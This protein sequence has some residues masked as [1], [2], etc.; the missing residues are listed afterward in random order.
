M[1]RIIFPPTVLCWRMFCLVVSMVFCALLFY[2]NVALPCIFKKT[3]IRKVCQ[4]KKKK[5]KERKKAYRKNH[6]FLPS[7][8]LLDN[9]T[10]DLNFWESEG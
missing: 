5:E 9:Q 10:T 4:K 6:N 2:E 3:I 1:G 7:I 8:P